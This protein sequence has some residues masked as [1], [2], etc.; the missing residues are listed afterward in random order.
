MLE[1]ALVF[2]LAGYETTSTA[3]TFALW[4]VA[5]RPDLQAAGHDAALS[6]VFDERVQS[7][8]ARAGVLKDSRSSKVPS[9]I[10]GDRRRVLAAFSHDLP[11]QH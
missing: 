5:A 6:S 8:T 2:L 7:G 3:L 11:S 10:T 9:R 4:E 1:Q